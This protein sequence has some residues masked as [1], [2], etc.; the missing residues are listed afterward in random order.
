MITKSNCVSLFFA[1]NKFPKFVV[2]ASLHYIMIT[3]CQNFL[4]FSIT[5]EFPL[6][7]Q[8]DQKAVS[9]LYVGGAIGA[10][11]GGSLCDHYGRKVTI[12]LTDIVFILGA[13]LL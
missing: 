4:T 2:R 12:M 6:N 11:I 5:H 3:K 8:F 13:L 9:I 10:C 7:V 1:Y